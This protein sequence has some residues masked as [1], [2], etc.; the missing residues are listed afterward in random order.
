MNEMKIGEYKVAIDAQGITISRGHEALHFQPGESTVICNLLGIVRRML[1]LPAMP[2]KIEEGP[3]SIQ[4]RKTGWAAIFKDGEPNG[5]SFDVQATDEVIDMFHMA[6]SKYVDF[7]TLQSG[8]RR[9][10]RS[11]SPDP[12]IIE[13][14]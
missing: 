13:G 5:L 4:F 9:G 8:P 7:T 3:F 11:T 2:P 1:G 12:G 6:V 10:L 14:R